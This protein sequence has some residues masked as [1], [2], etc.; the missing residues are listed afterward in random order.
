MCVCVCVCVLVDTSE[1]RWYK[2]FSNT[3]AARERGGVRGGEEEETHAW[4]SL[5]L[6]KRITTVEEEEEEEEEEEDLMA[7]WQII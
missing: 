1:L 5:R 4:R 3:L 2:C 7:V 6:A